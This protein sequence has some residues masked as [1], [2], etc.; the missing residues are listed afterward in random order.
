MCNIRKA[1]WYQM[2]K[3][4]L[5]FVATIMALIIPSCIV[6]MDTGFE[7]M[8]GGM[9]AV[10]VSEFFPMIAY[11]YLF[12]VVP[13]IFGGDFKDKVLNYEVLGGHN[14]KD[15]FGVRAG[16]ALVFPISVLIISF[17]IPIGIT[18]ALHGFGGNITLKE[19]VILYG[20]FVCTMIRFAVECMLITMLVGSSLMGQIFTCIG[21]EM[22][23]LPVV[24][25]GGFED[26]I[27][28]GYFSALFR[29]T[30]VLNFNNCR[31]GYY[32][33]EDIVQFI[34][35]PDAF[36]WFMDSA[37]AL[38]IAS[39]LLFITYRIFRKKNL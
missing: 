38:C 36:A 14:R 19:L 22:M 9:S 4:L 1:L 29:M 31:T 7:K 28:G 34:I 33:G 2:R 11:Y 37:G 26:E 35:K 39:L 27:K 30:S 21:E 10:A 6:F 13:K 8:S 12:L 23:M 16:M 18:T 17:V 32:N 24:I 25:V 5:L 3:D 20:M 15:V